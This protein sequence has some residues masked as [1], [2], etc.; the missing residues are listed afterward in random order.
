MEDTQQVE[1]ASDLL[2][3]GGWSEGKRQLTFVSCPEQMPREPSPTNVS[4]KWPYYTHRGSSL[5]LFVELYKV[6][7]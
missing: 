4:L 5:V 1:F 7:L 3:V 2:G 6:E